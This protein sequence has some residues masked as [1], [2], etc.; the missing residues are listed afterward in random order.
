M[1]AEQW[2]WKIERGGNWES[3]SIRNLINEKYTEVD[4]SSI[5]NFRKN[6]EV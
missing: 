4:M 2:V 1:V 6:H 3:S 5:E